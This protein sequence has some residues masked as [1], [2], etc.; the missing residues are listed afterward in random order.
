MNV[1]KIKTKL[2]LKEQQIMKSEMEEKAK[3]E[4]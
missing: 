4:Q 1:K 3:E 2:R